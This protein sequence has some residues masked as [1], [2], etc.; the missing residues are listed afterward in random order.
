MR[1]RIMCRAAYCSTNHSES[2][3]TTWPLPGLFGLN[4][5]AA[6][7]FK[8]HTTTKLRLE[9][10]SMPA[11]YYLLLRRSEILMEFD[12][13]NLPLPAEREILSV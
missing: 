12:G 7:K 3:F 5:H 11:S 13:K 8:A 1:L 10:G 9:R 6:L 4:W 2:S